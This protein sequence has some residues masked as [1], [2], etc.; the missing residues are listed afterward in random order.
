MHL[1][2]MQHF[3]PDAAPTR[4][5]ATHD[6]PNHS[7]SSAQNCQNY[8]TRPRPHFSQQ[9]TATSLN[10][11]QPSLLTMHFVT[12]PPVF[13]DKT[14]KLIPP[15]AAPPIRDNPIPALSV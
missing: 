14:Q 10:R 2:W 11:I 6:Q 5:K 13:F 4:A 7:D 3:L 1:T 8:Q 15:S 9:R 12:Q